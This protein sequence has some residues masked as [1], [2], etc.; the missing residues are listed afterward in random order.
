M[1][2]AIL[3]LVTLLALVQAVLSAEIYLPSGEYRFYYGHFQ[4]PQTHR[5]ATAEPDART[6]SVRTFP[7]NKDSKFQIWKVKHC[8]N[9]VVTIES[10]GARGK[11]LSPGR[12]GALPGAYVGVTT[13]KQRFKVTR[14]AGGPFTSYELAYPKK[15]F[16][17]TLVVGYDYTGKEEPYYLNFVHRRTEDHLWGWKFSR[18]K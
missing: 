10:K 12:S 7:L 8:G 2:L 18:V 3:A 6:G 17:R 9:N 1:H 5:F 15:V 13:T 14:V 16:N 11:Y 4:A